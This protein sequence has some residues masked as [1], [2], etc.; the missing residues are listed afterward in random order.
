MRRFLRPTSIFLLVAVAACGTGGSSGDDADAG[1]ADAS[2]TTPD[3]GPPAG[4]TKLIGRTWSL[5]AGQTDTYKCVRIKLTQD[6][7]ISAFRADAPL[8]THHTVVTVKSTL[9]PQDKLGEYDCGASALDPQMLFASGV[10]TDDM[11]FPDG[12][13]FKI[14]AGQY[15]NLNLHLFDA[16][17]HALQGETAIYVKPLPAAPDAAHTAEMIFAGTTQINIMAMKDIE[18]TAE[19]GCTLSADAKLIA[20]WPHMHQLATHQ[21]VTLTTGSDAPKILLDKPYAFSE[22]K[23]YPWTTPI[24]A[25]KGDKLW[26]KCTYVNTTVPLS[27]VGFGDSS[28][29]EMCFTGVYRYPATG[30]HLFA[31][32]GLPF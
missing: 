25:K 20:L 23:N 3:G 24:D 7:Y 5:T 22:Q 19:G 30:E 27:P 18:Q 4:F 6:I 1:T 13:G 11:V 10:G 31:C 17:D 2:T 28:L 29:D 9:G 16:T 14:A 8:G 21:L 26:T 15:V 32:A 12:V